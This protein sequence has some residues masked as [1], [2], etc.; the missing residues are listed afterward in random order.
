MELQLEKLAAERS[1]DQAKAEMAGTQVAVEPF[2][3]PF[4]S[5]LSS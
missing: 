1:E 3:V 4:C 2:T 5:P